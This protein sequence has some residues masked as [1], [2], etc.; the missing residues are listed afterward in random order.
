M[1]VDID[2]IRAVAVKLFCL[3]LYAASDHQGHDLLARDRGKLFR[4]SQELERDVVD[5]P[6]EVVAENQDSLP[7]V[8][9]YGCPGLLLEGD[10]PVALFHAQLAKPAPHAYGKP[11]LLAVVYG[12]ERTQALELLTGFPADFLFVY[13]KSHERPLQM[14]FLSERSSKSFSESSAPLPCTIVREELFSGG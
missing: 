13:H 6:V 14:N 1:V 3:L 2:L 4:L 12:S 9:V 11:V 5:L 8:F 7:F 10:R